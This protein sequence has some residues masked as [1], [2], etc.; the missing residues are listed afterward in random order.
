MDSNLARDKL[1]KRGRCR[2]TAGEVSRWGD[3]FEPP[4]PVTTKYRETL[5]RTWKISAFC[6]ISDTMRNAI[7]LVGFT[8]CAAFLLTEATYSAM[9]E[10]SSTSN[11]P[12]LR[13]PLYGMQTSATGRS[14]HDERITTRN[15]IPESNEI[16]AAGESFV[17]IDDIP[18]HPIGLVLAE[19]VRAHGIVSLVDFP[20]GEHRDIIPNVLKL[21]G[22]KELSERDKTWPKF[23]YHCVD[24]N[25]EVLSRARHNLQ[26]ELG[27]DLDLHFVLVDWAGSFLFHR[28][29][30]GASLITAKAPTIETGAASKTTSVDDLH[31]MSTSG[32]RPKAENEM[33]GYD[34][35]AMNSTSSNN[36]EMAK[37]KGGELIFSWSGRHGGK[38]ATTEVR[39]LVLAARAANAQLALI[40]AHAAYGTKWEL[41]PA[42]A[43]S[44]EHLVTGKLTGSKMPYFPFGDAVVSMSAAY[45]PSQAS[46]GSDAARFLVLYRLDALP[47]VLVEDRARLEADRLG[48]TSSERDQLGT[49][50][51]SKGAKFKRFWQQKFHRKPT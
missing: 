30:Q 18:I 26:Q 6:A 12:L 17:M 19:V 49:G 48:L 45:S 13:I 34:T 47:R 42:S 8:L 29:K 14:H 20:C 21:L 38:N 22:T 7:Q 51:S 4:E 24:T 28:G 43:A 15:Y 36:E 40:G 23:Q 37:T 27:D 1:S 39:E 11:P 16:G 35:K 10:E 32:S 25:R 46:G 33:S 31:R 41:P 3:N 44:I 50:K 2:N 9:T 5:G